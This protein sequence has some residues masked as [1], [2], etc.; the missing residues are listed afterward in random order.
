M[1]RLAKTLGLAVAATMALTACGAGTNDKDPASAAKPVVLKMANTSSEMKIQPPV[2]H[3]A[4]RV[5][6]LS[7]GSLVIEPVND[8]ADFASDAEQQV[9]RDVSNGKVDLGWVG[10]R[11]LDTMDV[12]AFEA[13][14]APML[15]DSYELE[16]A[17]VRSGII[18]EMLP[19][20]DKVGVTGLGV[21]PDALRKPV[22]VDHPLLS[23]AD[24]QGISFGT[25]RSN[26]QAAALKALGAQPAQLF[27]HERQQALDSGT[28]KGFEFGLTNY[29]DPEWLRAAR[30][31]TTNVNLW[32]QM[33]LL[34]ADPDRLEELTSQQRGWLSQAAKDAA[35]DAAYAADLE[36]QALARACAGGARLANAT[37][38]D[39]DQLRKAFEP[40]YATL[41]ADPQSKEFL[42]RIR[43]LKQSTQAAPALSI[44]AGCTGKAPDLEA[45]PAGGGP[46][47]DL[48]NGS[49]HY[50]LTQ[51]DADAVGD[52]DEGY[53]SPTT[54]TLHDGSMTGGCFEQ[55]TYTVAGDRI[56]FHSSEYG[57]DSTVRFKRAN[58]GDLTLT[59]VPP[60]DPG[61]AFACFYKPWEKDAP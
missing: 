3:F 1:S 33:D 46:T 21:L 2:S 27:G 26:S 43:A 58:N 10:T 60:M 54:I 34:I 47:T 49:Y 4:D 24:W 18:E 30:Y 37:P 22:A 55:G 32:P 9:V 14:T 12:A 20:L 19:A 36:K 44:P 52:T 51:A 28:L 25:L 31:V 23:V 8:Y 41:Q 15:V 40:V 6:A 56:T 48:L 35:G 29:L 45:A 42:S 5:A 11:G 17:V 7:K 57:T 59:P 39:L 16:D 38:T 13:L 50:V 61:D 53:P